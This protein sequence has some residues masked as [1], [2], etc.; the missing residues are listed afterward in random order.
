[1]DTSPVDKLD[2]VAIARRYF[3]FT[4]AEVD[5]YERF[6]YMWEMLQYV[7]DP[8]LTDE[9]KADIQARKLPMPKRWLTVHVVKPYVIEGILKSL[10]RGKENGV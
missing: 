10:E 8:T 3:G 7:V 4:S 6:D 1:M 5:C 2:T 9:Q